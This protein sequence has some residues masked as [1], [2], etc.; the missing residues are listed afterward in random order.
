M[1]SL[2]RWMLLPA[3]LGGLFVLLPLISMGLRVQWGSFGTLVTS[4]SSLQALRL[5]LQTSS[6]S[7]LV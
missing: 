3:L 4:E 1:R 2:P 6:T 7:A 5:S